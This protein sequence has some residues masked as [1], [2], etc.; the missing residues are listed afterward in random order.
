MMRRQLSL[1]LPDLHWTISGD[2][3]ELTFTLRRGMYGTGVLREIAGVVEA[4]ALK[5]TATS[6]P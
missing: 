2:T 6:Q 3:P 5:S 4:V 1:R